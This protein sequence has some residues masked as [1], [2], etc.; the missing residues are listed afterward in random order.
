VTPQHVE[1]LLLVLD[2]PRPELA[3]VRASEYV[4][5]GESQGFHETATCAARGRSS[6]EWYR[7]RR[8]SPA[9]LFI[10]II[11]KMR[12]ALG[13]NAAQA[14]S[15]DNC[16]EVRAHADVPV[17]ALSALLLGSFNF[18]SRHQAGRSY[19]RMLKVQ[20][21]EAERL[22]VCDP[23][24]LTEAQ[25]EELLSVCEPLLTQAFSWLRDDLRTP[26][27]VELD[28]AWLRVHGFA[29][30]AELD[31]ALA[32]IHAAVERLSDEMNAQEE[33]WTKVR[34]GVRRDGNPQDVMKGKKRRR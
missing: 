21:C 30:G 23:R 27:R 28:R 5:W 25:T 7:L 26:E 31:D 2:V 32:A 4:A 16:V 11:N 22:L 12:L 1:S 18:V 19:G 15:G 20:T 3:G 8:R 17:D 6:G 10:P 14:Q 33:A 24:L 13:I 9:D 29:D 34:G